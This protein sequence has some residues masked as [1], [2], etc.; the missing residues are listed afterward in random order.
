MAELRFTEEH[1]W[2]RIDG[3]EGTIG[4]SDYAQ[5]QLGDIVYVELPAVGSS[6]FQGDEAAV[7]ES[8]KAASEI[9][10]PVA[11]EVTAVNDELNGDPG[12]VNQDSMGAGWFIKMKV[13]N[14]SQLSE[15]MTEQTYKDMVEG[16]K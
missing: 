7:V 16:L 13:E 6:L 8:V 12:I 10:A 4:I 11:G 2:I 9:Y 14:T 5:E 3:N 1:E 15:L